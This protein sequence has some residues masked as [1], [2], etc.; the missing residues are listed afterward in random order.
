MTATTTTTT[1]ASTTTTTTTTSSNPRSEPIQTSKNNRTNKQKPSKKTSN[2][3]RKQASKAASKKNKQANQTKRE[4]KCGQQARLEP[5]GICRMEK[6]ESR[7][8]FG[9]TTPRPARTRASTAFSQSASPLIY[10]PSGLDRR[11]RNA[12]GQV[13]Q[14][15]PGT[16]VCC[17]R[18]W[19]S[20]TAQTRRLPREAKGRLRALPQASMR[21][22]ARFFRRRPPGSKQLRR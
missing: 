12:I 22:A 5:A 11:M 2:Q 15:T 13:G 7:A 18:K 3:A 16:L 20:C 6:A 21:G 17:W 14:R 1:T 4:R 19:R 9:A 10:P 8:L